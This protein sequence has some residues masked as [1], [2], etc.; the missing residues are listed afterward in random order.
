MY[1]IRMYG[2]YINLVSK[3]IS[4]KLNINYEDVKEMIFIPKDI[5]N[6]HFSFPC[7]KVNMIKPHLLAEKLQEELLTIEGLKVYVNGP[8][9]N[10]YVDLNDYYNV[11]LEK[12]INMGTNTEKNNQRKTVILNDNSFKF[13]ELYKDN[14]VLVQYLYY[15]IL[16]KQGFNVIWISELKDNYKIE[17]SRIYHSLIDQSIINEE[18]GVEIINLKEYNTCPYIIKDDYDRL[19]N[20]IAIYLTKTSEEEVSNYITFNSDCSNVHIEK[21]VFMKLGYKSISNKLSEVNINLS[22]LYKLDKKCHRI[23]QFIE[24]YKKNIHNSPKYEKKDEKLRFDYDDEKEL[25]K[26]LIKCYEYMM[27][28]IERFDFVKY[29]EYIIRIINIAEELLKNYEGDGVISKSRLK[30]LQ[31]SYKVV[32]ELGLK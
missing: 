6:G 13:M 3:K 20:N 9:L 11:A 25:I 2:N 19:N 1:I 31:V 21:K 5:K 29:Y 27:L 12:I 15:Q 17:M 18:N 23:M 28:D 4:E 14:I 8:Y 32:I 10:F 22:D 16:V 7:F 24:K 30:L 26:N